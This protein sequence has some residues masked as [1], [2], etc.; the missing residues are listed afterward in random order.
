MEI[1]EEET[2]KRGDGGGEEKDGFDRG[3][4]GRREDIKKMGEEEEKGRERG[5][6]EKA[7]ASSGDT[8]AEDGG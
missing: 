2:K 8:S 4:D 5:R 1:E 6:V 3:E 7:V